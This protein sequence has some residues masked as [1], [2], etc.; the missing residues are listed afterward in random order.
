MGP[1]APPAGPGPSWGTAVHRVLAQVFRGLAAER[2]MACARAALAEQGLPEGEVAELVGVVHGALESELWR[3]IRASARVLT[4]VPFGYAAQGEGEPATTLL[5]GAIDLAFREGPACVL[6]DFKTDAAARAAPEG[7]VAR[8]R[9]QLRQ[10]VAFWRDVLGEPVAEAVPLFTEGC[11]PSRS[12]GEGGAVRDTPKG[13]HVR[14]EMGTT[15]QGVARGQRGT[16][17]PTFTPGR[18]GM[19]WEIQPIRR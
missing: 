8:Y 16:S 5:D 12:R 7:L 17:D 18:D 9:G 14:S 2:W 19:G 10:C 15:P 13:D 3:R 4:A 1:P 6:V 11:T